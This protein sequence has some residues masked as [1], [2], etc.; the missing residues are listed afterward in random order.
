[1]FGFFSDHKTKNKTRRMQDNNMCNKFRP[2][3]SM[4]LLLLFLFY[5]NNKDVTKFMHGDFHKKVIE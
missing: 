2:L 3:F 5:S 4:I 1:M